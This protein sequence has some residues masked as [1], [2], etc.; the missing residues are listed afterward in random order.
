VARQGFSHRDD[1]NTDSHQQ[2]LRQ[3]RPRI[4]A[5]MQPWD[6]PSHGDVQESCCRQGQGIRQGLLRFVQAEVSNN[7]T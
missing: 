6:Q 4:S 3:A 5:A 7:A 2:D 1:T